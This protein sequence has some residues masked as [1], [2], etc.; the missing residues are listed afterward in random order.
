MRTTSSRVRIPAASLFV[1]LLALTANSCG[2]D[3]GSD[4]TGSTTALT[5]GDTSTTAAATDIAS[6]PTVAIAT[7]AP[8]I[9]IATVA[10]EITVATVAP[11]PTVA[12]S[13]EVVITVT[14]GVDSGDDRIESIPL[15]ATVTLT[16]SNPDRNDEFHVHGYELGDGVEVPAGESETFTFTADQAGQFEVE[17]HTTEAVL[18]ILDVG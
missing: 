14:A 6:D 18:L 11:D 17:S 9:T 4:S 8:E 12:T 2:S 7:V 15:G 13:N 16:V 1:A 10:S 5:A 3:D